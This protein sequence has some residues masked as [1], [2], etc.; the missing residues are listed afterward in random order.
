MNIR[1]ILSGLAA[2]AALCAMPETTHAAQIF[3]TN[4]G[5]GRIGQYT[6]S[7]ATVDPALIITL[8]G[9]SKIAVFEENLFVSISNVTSESGRIG[10][11]T[12]SGATVNP[13][14]IPGLSFPL[15]I[16]VSGGNLFVM[17]SVTGTIGEYNATT[18]A[19]V[20]AA[21][22]S[23]LNGPNGIAVSGG[24]LF[25]TNF[26]TGTIGEYTISGETVNASLISGLNEPTDIAVVSA[27]VADASSTWGLL[28]LAL[29][30]TFGLKPLLHRPA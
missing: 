4:F 1:L 13:D 19:I 27:S 9:P 14:L 12:T 2:S 5:T 6:T 22:I 28:L 7:G 11:F 8:G 25:V 30:A 10:K 15:G 26:Q 16:A 23:G 24:N 29:S 18:G 20:D 3:V 21:L 17:D